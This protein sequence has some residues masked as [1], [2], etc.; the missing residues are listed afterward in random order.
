MVQKYLEDYAHRFDLRR[1]IR[2]NTRVERLYQSKDDDGGP[3]TIESWRVAEEGRVERFD[4]VC[5]ANG[6]YSDGWIPDV[7]GLSYVH[8]QDPL[9]TSNLKV[10]YEQELRWSSTPFTVLPSSG[11]LCR[12]IGPCGRL[13]RFGIGYRKTNRISQYRSLRSRWASYYPSV[14][15]WYRE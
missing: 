10:T 3:W 13:F 15:L 12:R 4:Y 5:V 2:F 8:P 9:Q 1:H 6:H 14:G 11:R 7:Q